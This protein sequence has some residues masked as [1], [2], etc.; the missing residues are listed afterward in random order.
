MRT[1]GVRSR[2][3]RGYGPLL[4]FA[5]MFT[6]MAVF[7]PSVRQEV[8]QEVVS[9]G[10]IAGDSPAGSPG[11]SAASDSGEVPTSVLGETTI[12]STDPAADPAGGDPSGSA[13]GAQVSRS[14]VATRP[15][16]P[17]PRPGAPAV[18]AKPPAIAACGDHQVPSDPYSPPCIR[19]TRRQRRRDGEG[20]HRRQDR[21]RR[22]H[23]GVLV[24]PRRRDLEGRR[25]G[26]SRRGRGRHPPDARRT[27]R[28]LQPDLP[29]LRPQ[30]EARDLQRSR[31]RAEGECW[32]AARRAPRTT[33]C[34]SARRSRRSPTSR[35]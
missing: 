13:T 30:A 17:T 6:A 29:V 26:P 16:T 8:R 14:G 27:R 32:A 7:V 3:L 31:R 10:A 1:E 35:P 19:F 25:R 22:A 28:V 21:C 20:R 11:E 12:R 15:G 33:R 23:R 24:R 5:A 18:A 9:V 34:R 4:G 2:L